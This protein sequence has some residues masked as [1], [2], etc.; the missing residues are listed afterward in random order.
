MSSLMS[1]QKI[2]CQNMTGKHLG[3]RL[4][5]TVCVCSAAIA[6]R[7]STR[8]G[9]HVRCAHVE[10]HFQLRWRTVAVLPVL[11]LSPCVLTPCSSS[12]R[13]HRT[14]DPIKYNISLW[15]KDTAMALLDF[16]Q[17]CYYRCRAHTRLQAHFLADA[18]SG[19]LGA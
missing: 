17:V 12:W 7:H 3:Q 13:V 9:D 8:C 6:G 15:R 11:P 10:D 19:M 5:G 1:G 4:C 2:C 18:C 16:L 14:R